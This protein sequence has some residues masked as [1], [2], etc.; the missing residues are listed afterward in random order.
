MLEISRGEAFGE[1]LGC[2]SVLTFFIDDWVWVK[3]HQKLNLQSD[4]DILDVLGFLFTGIFD[5]VVF[6]TKSD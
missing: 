1:E 4:G 6:W 2:V 5:A 3:I